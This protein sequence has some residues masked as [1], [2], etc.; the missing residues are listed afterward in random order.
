MATTDF[1][2]WIGDNVSDI[3]DA[4]CLKHS[5]E[6]R[7]NWGNYDIITK[8]DKVFVTAFNETLMLASIKAQE[9][10]LS[11]LETRFADLGLDIDSSYEFYCQ[12]K[13]DD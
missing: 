5:I 9:T 13:K 1:D 8:S 2:Q 7:E 4:Y 3:E 12:M 10:F 11:I 6:N